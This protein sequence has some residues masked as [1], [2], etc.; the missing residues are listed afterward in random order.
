MA[1]TALEYAVLSDLLAKGRLPRGGDLLELGRQAWY[2]D[3]PLERLAALARPEERESVVAE[4]RGLVEGVNA[5]AGQNRDREAQ[6]GL[7]GIARLFY[8]LVLAPDSFTAVD[9][10]EGPGVIL[11]DL[12]EPL[13]LG[14]QFRVVTNIGTAEHVLDVR[15][16]LE[17]IHA[18]TE[19]GGLMIHTAPFTGWW[20]HGFYCL[21]P[22][23]FYDLAEANGYEVVAV[24]LGSLNPFQAILMESRDDPLRLARRGELPRHANMNYVLRKP[25]EHRPFRLPIQGYYAG[26]LSE[27][28]RRAWRELR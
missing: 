21:Q 15:R 25:D 28:G 6:E 27:E 8:R 1:I 20:D 24:T 3:V 18:H 17:A 19:P 11:H 16:V 13:D 2:G 12:N 10:D 4:L 5:L 14:R 22:T 23:L 7:F 26:K 9:L